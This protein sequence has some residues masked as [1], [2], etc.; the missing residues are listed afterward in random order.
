MKNKIARAIFQAKK[1]GSEIKA[2]IRLAKNGRFSSVSGKVK[3]LK[4][5]QDGFAYATIKVNGDKP[6][7]NVRLENILCLN[8]NNKLY[9]K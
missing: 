7:Q 4:V 2:N 6:Y 5:S 1:D 9:K 8:K 3:G